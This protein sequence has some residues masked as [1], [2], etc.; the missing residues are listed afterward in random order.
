[1]SKAN[2]LR[3]C[4]TQ[5]ACDLIVGR[6]DNDLVPYSIGQVL[7]FFEKNEDLLAD[8][9]YQIANEI[10]M[11]GPEGQIALFEFIQE[12]FDEKGMDP[13]KL[14]DGVLPLGDEDDVD[15]I[16]EQDFYITYADL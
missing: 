5:I 8:W 2:I 11:Y 12:T 9:V 14:I 3:V 15:K 13:D 16:S 7:E 6:L 4:K 10:S 1:M